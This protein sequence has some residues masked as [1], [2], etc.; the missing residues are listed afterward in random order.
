MLVVPSQEEHG[1]MAEIPGS[2]IV[3]YCRKCEADREHTV[4]E[5]DD[6]GK[7]IGKVRCK[8]CSEEHAFRRPKDPEARP[9]AKAPKAPKPTRSQRAKAAAE[10]SQQEAWRQ[11]ESV[12]SAAEKTPYAMDRPLDK[13]DVIQHPVFGTGVVVAVLSTTKVEVLFAD[14]RRKLVCGKPA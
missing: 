4:L 13:G 8:T 12:V 5:V 10:Q 7:R 14:A 1:A 2:T 9:K 6:G 3:A 11:V